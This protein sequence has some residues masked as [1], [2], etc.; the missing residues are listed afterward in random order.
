MSP[1][2]KLT[3][4]SIILLYFLLIFRDYIFGPLLY[5]FSDVGSDSQTLFYP[6]MLEHLHQYSTSLFD[7]WS[8][9]RG[10]G[11]NMM[12]NDIFDFTSW[13]IY[14]L[15]EKSIAHYIIYRQLIRILLACYFIY[16]TL[17]LRGFSPYTIV[18][19]TLLFAINGYLFISSGWYGHTKLIF[20]FCMLIY[21]IEL[22]FKRGVWWPLP[23]VALLMFDIKM[24]FVIEFLIIYFVLRWSDGDTLL[25]DKKAWKNLSISGLK[26]GL[27]TII[28]CAPFLISTVLKLSNSPRVVGAQSYTDELS[29]RG[30]TYLESASHYGTILARLFSPD[31]LGD[32]AVY[33]GWYNYLEGPIL[34]IGVFSLVFV[35]YSFFCISKRQ[36]VAY[37]FVFLVWILILV[38]PFLRYAFYG[39]SGDYYKSG[40]DIFIPFSLLLLCCHGVERFFS[41]DRVSYHHLISGVVLLV[42]VFSI[43]PVFG[44]PVDKNLLPIC[45]SFIAFYVGVLTFLPKL[46][47]NK[48]I[49]FYSCTILILAEGYY[50]ANHSLKSREPLTKSSLSKRTYINDY[51]KDILPKINPQ[52]NNFHRIEKTY[53]SR[54]L[55]YNDAS[56]QGYFST[57]S[58]NSHNHNNY[59]TFLSRY[60]LIDPNKESDSRWIVGLIS[61]PLLQPFFS[62]KYTLSTPETDQFVNPS[63]A[64]KIEKYQN[65]NIYENNFYLPF[66]IP[67][68]NM[69]SYSAFD[70]VTGSEAKQLSIYDAALI[71]DN[72]IQK[73]KNKVPS[74]VS[75]NIDYNI[76]YNGKLKEL[77]NQCLQMTSFKNQNI[78]GNIKTDKNSIL[79]FS[80]PHDIGWDVFVDGFEEET[81]RVNDG[82]L[83]VYLP[84]GAHKIELKYKLPFW[85]FSWILSALGFVYLLFVL[86]KSRS[87]VINPSITS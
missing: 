40:L 63:F 30:L 70:K 84:A 36:K 69:I 10:I 17:E 26:A 7:S 81:I 21:A 28:I 47:D 20:E 34:Y 13:P 15:N 85:T 56:A 65:I 51:T 59:V 80:M 55:G 57:R 16:K 48:N 3:L 1:K 68:F 5:I 46:I 50:M 19:G 24:V 77:S 39:F 86:Y 18:I 72:T 31:L 53:G 75:E 38:F 33:K 60:G 29:S 35:I 71:D 66:G 4:A 79:V 58:Y 49:L 2:T 14:F 87:A 6:Y 64:T 23:L 54:S 12:V 67:V 62:T 43:E 41:T 32:A 9:I 73:L 11:S 44:V 22:F 42:L 52:K 82:L 83:G 45:V 76:L 37:G 61:F 8:F 27:L 78:K 25:N 74:K